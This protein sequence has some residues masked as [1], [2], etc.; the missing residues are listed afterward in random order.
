MFSG[1]P[2]SNFYFMNKHAEKKTDKKKF[3]QNQE[4]PLIFHMFK[5]K[6]KF[7]L[8][9]FCIKRFQNDNFEVYIRIDDK[10]KEEFFW[11]FSSMKIIHKLFIKGKK[12]KYI[13]NG[14]KYTEEDWKKKILKI[15]TN[16]KGKKIKD[17]LFFYYLVMQIQDKK[18]LEILDWDE[19]QRIMC[20]FEKEN[21]SIS[22]IPCMFFKYYKCILMQ[23]NDLVPILFKHIYFLA[24][25]GISFVMSIVFFLF[26]FLINI[27]LN[28]VFNDLNYIQSILYTSSIIFLIL[29][30]FIM[31]FHFYMEQ[32]Y[33]NLEEDYHLMNNLTIHSFVDFSISKNTYFFK[34]LLN[35]FIFMWLCNL[36][37]LLN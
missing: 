20:Q 8:H 19:M 21:T 13:I 4:S 29:P 3:Y 30:F 27:I 11:I 32:Q 31:F 26:F 25:L 6:E 7:F 2:G 33:I 23:K 28:L 14:Q 24:Y 5:N 1:F 22:Q 18:Y 15:Y 10:R 16:L 36:L 9:Q 35:V 37:Y 12:N 34:K 17:K